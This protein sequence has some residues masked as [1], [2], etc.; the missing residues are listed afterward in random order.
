MRVLEI[1]H[2]FPPAALGGT[3]LYA[4]RHALALRK[5]GAD[6]VVLAREN[7]PTRADGQLRRLTVDGIPVVFLNN[8]F[9]SVRSFEETYR[10]EHITAAAA[11]VIDEVSP[12]LA[13]IHHLTGLSTTIVDSLVERG[14]PVFVTL[15]DYWLM[16]HRGQLLDIDLRVCTG[17]GASGCHR[18]LGAAAGFGPTGFAGA[19]LIRTVERRLPAAAGRGL[20]GL[21]AWGAALIAGADEQLNQEQRR[22][23]HMRAICR[24]VTHFL[25]PSRFIRDR[26]VEFG[27]DGARIE[28]APN[29]VD[30]APFTRVS[31]RAEALRPSLPLRLG[32]VGTM[33]ASKA[34]H[35]LLEAAARLPPGSATVDLFGGW[36]AYHGDERYRKQLEPLLTRGGVRVHGAIAHRALVGA[37]QSIDVLVVPSIWPENAPLVIQEAFL[38]GLPVVASRVG[39]IPEMI[40]DGLNG[41]LFEPGDVAD[42]WRNLSRLLDEPGLLARLRSGIPQVRS[43]DDDVRQVWS[44][45]ETARSPAASSRINGDRAAAG[46]VPR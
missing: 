20:R 33:M 6:V 12:D 15:H 28:I 22:V 4:R 32:F 9:A 17:P 43:I 46:E 27:V 10:N 3:E 1:V 36:A 34:P 42:L 14:I 21:A 38:A 45:Y 41:M 19:A 30:H 2:G 8:T 16:C 18:C 44:M 24:Q 29:G 37:L 25:A 13:H 39:G 35:L 31:P 23:D 40:S 5:V 7:D 11:R 26:F